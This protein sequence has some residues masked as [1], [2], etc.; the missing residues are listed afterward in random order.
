MESLQRHSSGRLRVGKP[1]TQSQRVLRGD[2]P[3]DL[4]PYHLPGRIQNIPSKMKG[5]LNCFG[6]QS[7]VSF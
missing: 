1:E 3:Q 6:T 2:L 7:S 4:E 5:K